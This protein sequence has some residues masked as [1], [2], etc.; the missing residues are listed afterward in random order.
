M[1]YKVNL[2][3]GINCCINEADNNRYK[4]PKCHQRELV[5][6]LLLFFNLFVLLLSHYS[7][8]FGLFRSHLQL[9]ITESTAQEF[10]AQQGSSEVNHHTLVCQLTGAWK[11]SHKA[12]PF[13]WPPGGSWAKTLTFL[14][15]ILKPSSLLRLPLPFSTW[16]QAPRSSRTRGLLTAAQVTDVESPFQLKS[17]WN[18]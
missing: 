5:K 8:T 18:E 17:K 7:P 9:V 4:S 16:L 1:P 11:S 6:D 3:N 12:F 10:F 13:A 2:F 15:S 14:F